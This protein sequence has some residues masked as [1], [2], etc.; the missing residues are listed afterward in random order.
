M[1]GRGS[2]PIPRPDPGGDHYRIGMGLD[3]GPSCCKE[4]LMVSMEDFVESVG[5]L[6]G[7]QLRHGVVEDQRWVKADPWP[8]CCYH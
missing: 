8:A 6:R 2:D 4:L 7:R 1:S 3:E 5:K